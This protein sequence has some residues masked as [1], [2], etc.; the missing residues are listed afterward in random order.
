VRNN[1]DFCVD[2]AQLVIQ[3]SS[4]CSTGLGKS[5]DLLPISVF[6]AA[7]FDKIPEYLFQ[8]KAEV[9]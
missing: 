4:V 2:P 7:Q 9:T 1:P 6:V 8:L 3:T 5:D